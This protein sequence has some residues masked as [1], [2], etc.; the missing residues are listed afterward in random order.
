MGQVVSCGCECEVQRQLGQQ[1]GLPVSR[2]QLVEELVDTGYKSKTYLAW[3]NLGQLQRKELCVLRTYERGADLDT[4]SILRQIRAL[5][6]LQNLGV[7]RPNEVFLTKTH[8]VVKLEYFEGM[9][10]IEHVYKH[11][12]DRCGLQEEEGRY[13]FRQLVEIVSYCYERGVPPSNLSPNSVGVT[14]RGCVK[15]LSIGI[16]NTWTGTGS[17]ESMLLQDRTELGVLDRKNHDKFKIR[18]VWHL[19]VILY[20]L[21]TGTYPYQQN[22]ENLRS[23]TLNKRRSPLKVVDVNQHGVNGGFRQNSPDIMLD[24]KAQLPE[25]C[26]DVLEAMLCMDSSKRIKMEDL[27]TH[28]WVTGPMTLDH[29]R[30]YQTI[31]ERNEIANTETKFGPGSVCD[32]ELRQLVELAGM[33]D[34]VESDKQQQQQLQQVKQKQYKQEQS[35]MRWSRDSQPSL[36]LPDKEYRKWREALQNS[37]ERERCSQKCTYLSKFIYITNC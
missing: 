37:R 33:S 35:C 1:Y 11:Q 23:T 16:S 19:G 27:R 6:I 13:I 15:L 10:L 34:A 29:A 21:L 17:K 12:Q 7:P 28:P 22:E 3:E 2:Y 32:N 24:C 30:A 36:D 4:Q 31:Q 8:L 5:C 18:D 9:S 26:R 25:K 20:V 14:S